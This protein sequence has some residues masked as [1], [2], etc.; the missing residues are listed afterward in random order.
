MVAVGL[1]LAGSATWWAL[2]HQE[3]GSYDFNALPAGQAVYSFGVVLIV[4]RFAPTFS[5]VGRIRALDRVVTIV[6]GRALVIYLWH[7]V[8]IELSYP[9][10][11]E[12]DVWRYGDGAGTALCAVIAV[13]LTI[14]GMLAFGW[15]EDVAA[16]RRPHLLP[17]DLGRRSA[18]PASGGPAVVIPSPAPVPAVET[19][20]SGDDAR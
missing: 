8:A 9:V 14:A 10:G 17:K 4:L 16:Q 6:N 19:I 13:L 5:R 7:N 12:L 1:V 15:I 3:D 18:A 20:P 2:T 11:D